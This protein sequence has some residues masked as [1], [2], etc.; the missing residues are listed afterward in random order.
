MC[1]SDPYTA[2]CIHASW[3]T[4]WRYAATPDCLGKADC[5]S[6]PPQTNMPRATAWVAATLPERNV[7]SIFNGPQ[8]VTVSNLVLITLTA[9]ST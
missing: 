1:F 5:F 3:Y 6:T 7:R 8:N 2:L 9:A 4:S